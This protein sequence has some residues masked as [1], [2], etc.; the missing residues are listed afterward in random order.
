LLSMETLTD[1]SL[2]IFDTPRFQ[3]CSL[4]MSAELVLSSPK[5]LV[6]TL[7]V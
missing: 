5:L 1:D 7:D 3:S 4:S 6:D 2:P